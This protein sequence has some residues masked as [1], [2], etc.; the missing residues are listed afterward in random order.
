MYCRASVKN[1]RDAAVLRWYRSSSPVVIGVAWAVMSLLGWWRA[2]RECRRGTHCKLVDAGPMGKLE[3]V[4]RPF[5][6]GPAQLTA[7]VRARGTSWQHCGRAAIG[8]RVSSWLPSRAVCLAETPGRTPFELRGRSPETRPDA[9]T[10]TSAAS[11]LSSDRCHE[12][13]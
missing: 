1:R 2:P 5:G 7:P 9:P 10:E 8:P 13:G 3:A 11:P 6:A 4:K 12:P